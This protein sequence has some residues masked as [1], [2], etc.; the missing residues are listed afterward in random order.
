M[1]ERTSRETG[2]P[3]DRKT[4]LAT[5]LRL[6]GIQPAA[7][8]S[9]LCNLESISFIIR[10]AP[11]LPRDS[12]VKSISVSASRWPSTPNPASARKISPGPRDTPRR[13]DTVAST[14]PGERCSIREA[15][16]Y[17]IP[18]CLRGAALADRT[19]LSPARVRIG[20]WPAVSLSLAPRSAT[21]FVPLVFPLRPS[22]PS[23]VPFALVLPL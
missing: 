5:L 8:C 7:V 1:R 21:F 4:D 17:L 23:A 16:G 10:N 3:A 9:G 20:C 14:N 12:C 11:L 13:R 2:P 15:S 19:P 22:P 18:S 6:R